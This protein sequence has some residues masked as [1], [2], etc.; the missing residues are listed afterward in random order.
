MFAVADEATWG[1]STEVAVSVTAAGVGEVAGAVYVIGTPDA[2]LLAEIV[3]HAVLV[4]PVPLSTHVTPSLNG[5]P[6]TVAVNCCVPVVE[7][8][9]TLGDTVTVV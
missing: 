6:V 2:V 7:R 9:A 3:P 4:H 5:S 8:F 1:L